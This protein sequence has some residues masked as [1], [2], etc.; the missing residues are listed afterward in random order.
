MDNLKYYLECLIR[1]QKN[2]IIYTIDSCSDDIVKLYKNPAK[3]II[4]GGQIDYLFS[5]VCDAFKIDTQIAISKCRKNECV[6]AR[7]MFCILAYVDLSIMSQEKIGMYIGGRD[8][9]T[10]IN[11]I[12][13][14][15]NLMEYEE[16]MME[17]Y[18]IVKADFENYLLLEN[19]E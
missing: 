5:I 13:I 7:A 16:S 1:G 11:A 4:K 2:G 12:K 8:H 10:V 6:F 17:K 14:F 9:S 15:N 3:K 19:E 18:S